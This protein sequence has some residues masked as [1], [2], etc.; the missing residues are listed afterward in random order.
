MRDSKEPL[1]EYC[2][3]CLASNFALY[4]LQVLM[5]LSLENGTAS[6]G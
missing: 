6:G 1:E 4:G 3:F 5:E 2:R